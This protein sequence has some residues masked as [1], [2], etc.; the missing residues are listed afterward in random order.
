MTASGVTPANVPLSGPLGTDEKGTSLPPV[1]LSG[2]KLGPAK[3]ESPAMSFNVKGVPMS[4]KFYVQGA[5]NIGK[6][7]LTFTPDMG[8]LF[9]IEKGKLREFQAYLDGKWVADLSTELQ[10]ETGFTAGVDWK[11]AIGEATDAEK[12]AFADAMTAFA[13]GGPIPPLNA[14]VASAHVNLPTWWVPTPIGPIPV[15]SSLIFDL[16]LACKLTFKG[17]VTAKTGVTATANLKVG[18]RYLNDNGKEGWSAIG[19]K[20]FTVTPETGSVTGALDA[21]A[22]CTLEPTF[23]LIFY[24][25]AG[26]Y[27]YASASTTASASAKQTCDGTSQV[28][29]LDVTLGVKQNYAFGVGAKLGLFVP[30]FDIDYTLAEADVKL[31]N[32]DWDLGS[33][34]VYSGYPDLGLFWCAASG[35]S[36][37]TGGSGGSGGTAGTGGTGGSSGGGG[38]GGTSSGGA[39]SGG[40]SGG[41]GGTS[42]DPCAGKNTGYYCG[43]SSQF[44]Y[45][46]ASTLYLCSGGVLS[47]Q[48]TCAN[49]CIVNP[50]GTDDA[51]ST[52]SPCAGK[53]SGWYCGGS[54]QFSYGDPS[55]RYYCSGGTLSTSEPCAYGCL[56]APPGYNDTC[57]T[58]PSCKDPGLACSTSSECCTNHCASNLCCGTP[59]GSPCAF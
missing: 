29:K 49:G 48:Q 22:S 36:G 11:K 31:F 40:G 38:S 20:S 28:P 47:S 30:A 43:A 21:S 14:K 15:V 34:N 13:K 46:S 24:G 8:L 19:D 4:G 9:D 50:P 35:G 42:S 58:A 6:G 26:P 39:S 16:G 3:I 44:P 53:S 32:L 51:C 55:T 33:W 17:T 37:G 45:G 57:K 18:A 52:T 12:K 56:V 10:F 7:S 59:P 1:E 27:I 5:V 2:I 41:S 54:S 23:S 25:V